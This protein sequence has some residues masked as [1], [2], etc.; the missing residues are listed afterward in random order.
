M[1]PVVICFGA[2]DAMVAAQ[3]AYAVRDYRRNSSEK[4][5]KKK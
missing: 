5:K 4:T 2:I 1:S 3:A